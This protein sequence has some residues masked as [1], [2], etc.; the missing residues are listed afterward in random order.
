MTSRVATKD[1]LPQLRELFARAN[2]APYDLAAVAEEKCFGDGIVGAPITTIV[3]ER[4]RIRAAA[5]RCGKWLR[6]L[7]VDRDARRQGLA[8]RLLEDGISVIAAE[9]G[10]YFTP[11]VPLQDEGALAFFKARGFVETATTWN[12]DV[13][14]EKGSFASPPEVR[15]P[16]Y[17]EAERVLAFVERAFGRVWRFEAAKAFERELPPAFISEAGGEI[18]GFAVHDVNNRG[19]GWFGPTGVD[20][21]MRGRGVGG[22]LLVASL[23]DLQRLGYDNAVI[24]WTDALEF[25]RKVAGAIPAQ[26]FIAFAKSQP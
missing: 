19:L 24:P 13:A 12:L 8:T 1:D 3:E 23:G 15:R 7:I 22:R 25:Y 17:D 10:N 11:G 18:I 14:L 26:Q 6:V 4:G 2:D 16:A 21:T 20:A 9:P 5:V